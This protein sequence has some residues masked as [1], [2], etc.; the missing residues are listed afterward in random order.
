MNFSKEVLR[1]CSLSGFRGKKKKKKI[2]RKI[3]KKKKNLQL[4][5]RSPRAAAAANEPKQKQDRAGGKKKKTGQ[6][7][8]PE[9]CATVSGRD[10]KQSLPGAA[11]RE[12]CL[13][14]EEP[15]IVLRG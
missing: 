9:L 3:Q 12:G 5:H 13:L 10:G 4:T 6:E 15:L 8:Q 1:P 11:R 7:K 2:G 14:L